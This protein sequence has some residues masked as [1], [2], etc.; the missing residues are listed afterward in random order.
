MSTNHYSGSPTN[1]TRGLG[2]LT[3]QS[4]TGDDHNQQATVSE[5]LT[6]VAMSS[7][8]LVSKEADAACRAGDAEN[9]P[10]YDACHGH[11]G[12]YVKFY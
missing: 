7:M 2:N 1:Y 11:D 4:H 12:D 5:C 3:N 8:V 10:K 9:I 6:C